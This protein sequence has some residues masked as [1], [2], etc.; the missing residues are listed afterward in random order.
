[1]SRGE[2]CED[3]EAEATAG[4]RFCPRC[5]A[6]DLAPLDDRETVARIVGWLR[7]EAKRCRD[8]NESWKVPS[9]DAAI[10][11]HTEIYADAIERGDWKTG[12]R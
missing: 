12:G 3:C 2:M 4:T 11:A 5:S 10:A 6:D 8:R 7:A 9:T 1:M